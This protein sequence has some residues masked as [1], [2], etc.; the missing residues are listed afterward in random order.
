MATFSDFHDYDEESQSTQENTQ[1]NT[2]ESCYSW[3][4]V[5]Q[6]LDVH[7]KKHN[8]SDDE[9]K[10]EQW[11]ESFKSQP[12]TQTSTQA[13]QKFKYFSLTPDNSQNQESET[14][15]ATSSQSENPNEDKEKISF[16]LKLGKSKKFKFM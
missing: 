8:L 13:S 15:G 2:Q 10:E 16:Y 7:G 14:E 9:S 5:S 4:G 12:L 11:W 3:S 6:S 1:G